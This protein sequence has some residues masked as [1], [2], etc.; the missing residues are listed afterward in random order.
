[1]KRRDFLGLGCLAFSGV[2]APNLFASSGFDDFTIYG[3]PAMPSVIIGVATLQGRLKNS[4]LK[5]WQ[6]PDQ[7]RAG[8]AS[9]SMQVMMSP[10]NVCSMLKNKGFDVGYVNFL[11]TSITSLIS[12]NAPINELKELEEKTIILPFKNDMPDIVLNTLLRYE[13]VDVS[14]VKIIYSST[15]V[16]A[17]SL[18]LSKD[19]IDAAYI[20]EPMASAS[21]LKAKMTS[22]KVYKGVSSDE[23]WKKH[24]GLNIY[25]AGIIAKRDFYAN[26][27]NEFEI[28]HQ[29]LK[30]ALSWSMQNPQSAAN[31]GSNFLK[32]PKPALQMALHNSNLCVVK[33]SEVKKDVME[34]LSIINEYNP[35]LIGGKMPKDDIFLS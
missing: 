30:D 29:D 2:L 13:G 34:F 35:T 11:I 25:Q 15:P 19:D 10:A 16:E 1:M 8:V 17:L 24:F 31:I 26:H 28:L 5:I 14:R 6:N 32:A 7:L 4:S 12:K 27:Q 3:A 22:K 33:A 20:P 18:F 9:G 21:L 23:I